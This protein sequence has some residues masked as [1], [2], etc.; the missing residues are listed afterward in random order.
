[1]DAFRWLHL[2]DLHWGQTGQRPSWPEIRKRFFEDLARLHKK[3]GPWHA[4]LFTGDLV[5]KGDPDEFAQLD[6][7]VFGPLWK[8]FERLGSNPILLTVP[9]NHD[10]KRPKR[11]NPTID[12]LLEPQGYQKKVG[13]FW[14]NKRNPYRRA[15]HNT[16]KAYEAWI[17][18]RPYSQGHPIHPGA[19]PGDFSTTLTTDGGRRIGIVGLNTTFL[20]LA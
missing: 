11:K 5:Q 4:V 1:M 2:T 14:T 3:T 8:C 6:S 7:E 13:E 17:K 16:F 10:L 15:V 12:W 19:L 20:Q 9:G 18:D